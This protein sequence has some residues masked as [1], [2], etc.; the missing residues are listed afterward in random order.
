MVISEN[1]MFDSENNVANAS[2]S[3][4]VARRMSFVSI[5]TSRAR[6]GHNRAGS[7]TARL[8]RYDGEGQRSRRLRLHQNAAEDIVAGLDRTG[9]L[10]FD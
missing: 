8:G 10:D 7:S 9:A 3:T 2:A 4:I 1:G 5:V 6:F